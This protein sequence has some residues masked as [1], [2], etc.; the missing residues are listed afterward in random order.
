ML[1]DREVTGF[2]QPQPNQ[3]KS[4]RIL[5]ASAS[6]SS[7]SQEGHIVKVSYEGN[8]CDVF[9]NANET[10]LSGLE[11]SS[12]RQK[13]GLNELPSDCR[14]GNCLTCTGRHINQSQT[15]NLHRLDDGLAPYISNQVEKAGYVLTCSSLVTGD[16]VELELGENHRAW[17][18][19][20][21]NR[22][23]NEETQLT[24]RAAMAKTIR[25]YDENHYDTWEKETKHTLDKTPSTKRE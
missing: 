24:G 7:T 23:L 12:V 20:Y 5:T 22:I 18:D 4:L 17:E 1:G 21:Y 19:I 14:R 11:R 10:I 3:R 25:L 9:I 8:S 6:Q 16:G 13:L 15:S 2:L